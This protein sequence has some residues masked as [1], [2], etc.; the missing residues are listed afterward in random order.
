MI[1]SSTVKVWREKRV[2]SSTI[3]TGS[4]SPSAP[5]RAARWLAKQA[6][7]GAVRE[8]ATSPTSAGPRAGSRTS[9]QPSWSAAAKLAS[10]L[11]RLSVARS[12]LI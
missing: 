12:R 6:F 9:S 5:S 8:P 11:A 1:R 7:C 3:S 4:P 2:S 10:R